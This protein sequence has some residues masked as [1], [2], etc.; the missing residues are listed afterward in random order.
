MLSGQ[1]LKIFSSQVPLEC[2]D[3]WYDFAGFF[4]DE[5]AKK[6]EAVRKYAKRLRKEHIITYVAIIESLNWPEDK[7]PGNLEEAKEF[8]QHASSK[9][10]PKKTLFA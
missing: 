7:E 4:S 9:F 10:S 1:L 3:S 2:S 8:V 6:L 5:D